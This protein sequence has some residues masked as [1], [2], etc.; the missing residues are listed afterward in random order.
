MMLNVSYNDI[1]GYYFGAI[2]LL[3]GITLGLLMVG[4]WTTLTETQQ[5]VDREASTLV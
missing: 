1:V 4:D 2:T 5:K 3:Y